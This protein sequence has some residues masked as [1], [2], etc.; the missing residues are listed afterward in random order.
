MIAWVLVFG[1][2]ANGTSHVMGST[3]ITVNDIESQAECVELAGKM[4]RSIEDR[5]FVC[6]SYK[7]QR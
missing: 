2:I 6:L 1:I 3:T 7:K 4:R 5:P